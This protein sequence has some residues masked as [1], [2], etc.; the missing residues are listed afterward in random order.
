MELEASPPLRPPGR[1]FGR[2]GP[3]RAISLRHPTPR[4]FVLTATALVA[5]AAALL[6]TALSRADANTASHGYRAQT[7]AIEHRGAE[8]PPPGWVD[9]EAALAPQAFGPATGRPFAD[10]SAWN[11]PI[12]ANPVL[13]PASRGITAYL[14]GER[15]GYANLYA[16]GVPVYDADRS[17]PRYR[18]DCT[19]PWGRCPLEE[20]RVPIP[21]TA[22]PSPGTDG[23][24]VVID[25]STRRAYEFWQA[26]R[27]ASGWSASWGGVSS[28]DGDGRGSPATGAGVSRLAG[29]VRAF[30]IRQGRIDHALVFSTDNACRDGYREP[31]TKTDGHSSRP[32]CIPEGARL[33]LDPSI[34]L[35]A[36]PA[37]TPG[38]RIVA[39]ALQIYGAY[40][41]DN[42][43]ARLAV[44]FET[45]YEE[46]DPYPAAG[47]PHDYYAMPHVPWHRLRVLRQWDGR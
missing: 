26:R 42:G 41:I 6:L 21:D 37:M 29:V 9:S 17:T 7:H 25:W 22:R 27:S 11:T 5:L 10:A 46:Q 44:I 23:A 16:Y 14:G 30:E 39:R 13:D 4:S 12:P 45:P 31:A 47:F 33:Q 35:D 43:G 18:V 24:M 40:A 34:N 8:A 3:T 19:K 36:I 20:H 28:I 1:R 2:E 32:D 15:R 38:E